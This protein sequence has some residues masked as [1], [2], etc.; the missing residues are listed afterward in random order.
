MFTKDC[1]VVLKDTELK[2]L[3]ELIKNSRRSDRELAKAIGVSQPTVSRTLKRLEKAESL[4]YS[5]IPD[6]AKLGYEILAVTL[7][8]HRYEVHP[9]NVKRAKDFIR[10][11]PNIIFVASGIG[12]KSDRM[13]ISIHRNYSD[14]AKF[15][16]EI[17]AE[18]EGYIHTESFLV[19]L[20]GNDV[21]RPLSFK[22]VADH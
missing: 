21:L 5:A 2:L 19:D 15:M 13:A 20:K 3:S 11:H 17:K 22:H 4:E 16:N 18:W 9:E 1:V 12:S 8:K 14:Y 6:L 7:G 10:K